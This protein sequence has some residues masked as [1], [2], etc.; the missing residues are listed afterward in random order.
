MALT[1]TT[2]GSWEAESVTLTQVEAALTDLRRQEER[3][4]VR[5]SVLTFVVVIDDE[6]AAE[7]ILDVVRD[8]GGRHPSRSLVLVLCD[9]DDRDSVD[10]HATLQLNERDGRTVCVEDVVLFVH[11]RGRFHLDSLVQ[12][13]RLPDLPAVVWSPSKLPSPGNPLLA[14]ADR[15][16]I[17][18]RFL[19]QDEDFF[20]RVSSLLKRFP[21]D[22]MSW[23]RLAAWRSLLAGLFEGPVAHDYL[24]GVHSV[25]VDGHFGPRHLLAGWLVNR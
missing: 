11:G 5:T 6:A 23:V 21:I 17:D 15:V 9:D 18:S 16:I 20:A 4:A 1:S 25:E 7:D 19:P 14:A 22:D 2:L 10:A 24:R 3:A 12:P 13:L 8:L